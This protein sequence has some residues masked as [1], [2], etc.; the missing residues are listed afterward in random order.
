MAA[1]RSTKAK[2]PHA[3]ADL[4]LQML[5]EELE[6]NWGA[7]AAVSLD[8]A[9]SLSKIDHWVST[10]SIVIDNVLAG[11]R[12]RP[13]SLMPFGRQI[14]VSGPPGAGKTSLCAQTAAEVQRQGGLVIVTD[15]EER[16]DHTYWRALGVDTAR[17]LNLRADTIEEVFEKQYDA[18]RLMQAKAPD[19]LM[20]MIWD[21]VGGTSSGL[22]LDDDPKK[23]ETFMERAQK[24]M[25]REAK[26]IGDGIKGLSGAV[27]KSRVCYLYTNHEY[28]KIGVTYGSNRETYGGNKLKFLATARIQLTPIGEIKDEDVMGNKRV[29]GSR[30]RVK[31]LKNSMA[32]MRM[33]KEAV[34]IGG[35]GFS[36]RYTVWEVAAKLKLIEKSGSWSTWKTSNGEEIKFQGWSGFCEKVVTHAEYPDLEAAVIEK[37]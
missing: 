26:L 18:I 35:E 8:S 31:A 28:N 1:R 5:Q 29:L 11:G 34:I 20:L 33:E 30:I 6:K 9:S 17:V 14:E 27:A 13:C 36:N 19:R 23:K 4:H 15:T 25:G 24:Q 3:V 10:R 16:I 22:V 2:D 37:L 12:P 21:S 32:P 7:N